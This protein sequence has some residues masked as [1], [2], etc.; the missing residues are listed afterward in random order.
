[1]KVVAAEKMENC[2]DGDFVYKYIFD[3]QWTREAIMALDALGR[4][5]FY[6][7]FPK[8]MFQ[9]ACPDDIFIKG[10]QGTFECRV[11]YARDGTRVKKSEFEAR[12]TGVIHSF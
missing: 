2:F 12:F 7:D 1:M 6:E 3:S 10:V 11:I 8:P 5:R 9:L 4:L